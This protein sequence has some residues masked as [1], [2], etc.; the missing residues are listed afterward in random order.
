MCGRYRAKST[1]ADV[2]KLWRVPPNE[3]AERTLERIEVKPTTRV[4]VLQPGLDAPRMEAVRWGV[5]PAWSKS[6]RP[7]INARSDKLTSSRLWKRLAA[8]AA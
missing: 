6:S 3:A 2:E 7:I 4:A 5:Q 8:N 1:G